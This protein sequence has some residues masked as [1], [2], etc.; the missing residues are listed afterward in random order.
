MQVD[1][2]IVT[3]DHLESVLHDR[4]ILDLS[5]SVQEERCSNDF[6]YTLFAKPKWTCDNI[7]NIIQILRDSYGD[8]FVDTPEI[9][10]MFEKVQQFADPVAIIVCILYTIAHEPAVERAVKQMSQQKNVDKFIETLRERVELLKRSTYNE[11]SIQ[12]I[13]RNFVY[14]CYIEYMFGDENVHDLSAR[15]REPMIDSAQSQI[16]SSI[17]ASDSRYACGWTPTGSIVKKR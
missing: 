8:E 15:S 6:L 13:F 16:P 14:G 1:T 12:T 7:P 11:L 17:S 9:R 5:G 4:G 10:G 3:L 2:S